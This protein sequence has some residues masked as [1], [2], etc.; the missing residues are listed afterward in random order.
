MAKI[1]PLIKVRFVLPLSL[2]VT[3]H[4]QSSSFYY[5]QS[6][7]YTKNKHMKIYVNQ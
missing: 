6:S 3:T 1:E 2:T 4:C 7:N 5:A